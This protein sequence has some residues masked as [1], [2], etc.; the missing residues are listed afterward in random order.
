MNAVLRTE[1]CFACLWAFKILS[2][3]TSTW[4]FWGHSCFWWW[5][6]RG[7]NSNQEVTVIIKAGNVVSLLISGWQ[8]FFFN[9]GLNSK[10][11]RLCEPECPCYNYWIQLCLCSRKAI[12]DHKEV[13]GPS[14]VLMR[15]FTDQAGGQILPSDWCLPTPALNYGFSKPFWLFWDAFFS[16]IIIKGGAG[17]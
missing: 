1:L 14:C 3:G 16:L 8:T 12:L 10:Y 17:R 11:F 2:R 4:C 15:L 13:N 7:I 6:K 9:K 5:G